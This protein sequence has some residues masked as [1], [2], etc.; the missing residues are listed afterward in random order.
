MTEKEALFARNNIFSFNVVSSST[1]EITDPQFN[2]SYDLS[3]LRN[4][5]ADYHTNDGLYD[6]F[7]NICGGKLYCSV[8]ITLLVLFVS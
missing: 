7:A 3:L 1:C 5:L 2:A 8:R 6:H 4:S